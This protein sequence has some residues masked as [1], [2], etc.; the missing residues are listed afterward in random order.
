MVTDYS[1]QNGTFHYSYSLSGNG[2]GGTFTWNS[3]SHQR[4]DSGGDGFDFKWNLGRNTDHDASSA[5]DF[6]QTV[7]SGSGDGVDVA[8]LVHAMTSFDAFTSHDDQGITTRISSSAE[9]H[10]HQNDFHLV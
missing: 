3:S 2:H 5:S 10:T 9:F 8:A 1:N 7:R 6:T 4:Y